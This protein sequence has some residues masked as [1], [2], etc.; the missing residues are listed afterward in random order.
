MRAPRDWGRPPVALIGAFPPPVGGQAIYNT[1]LVEELRARGIRVAEVDVASRSPGEGVPF[2]RWKLT[3]HLL[4]K[5]FSIYHLTASDSRMLG[6]E[7]IV[8]LA[9]IVRRTPFVYN[10]LA[11]RF[12]ARMAGYSWFHRALLCWS[13]RRASRILLSNQAMASE[14]QRLPVGATSRVEVVGCRLPLGIE[15]EEDHELL[16]FL[17]GG[18]PAIVAVGALRMVYGFDLLARA[19]TIL[20]ARGLRPHLLVIASGTAEPDAQL[21]LDGAVRESENGW[22]MVVRR[23]VDRACVLGAIRAATVLAR[24]TRADGDSLSIHEAQTLGVPVVASDAAPR[25]PGVVL[26]RSEDAASLAEAIVRACRIPRE[27][28]IE[29]ATLVE[30]V[31]ACYRS[32]CAG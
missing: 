2:T 20:T 23:D 31:V 12:A 27:P 7:L 4:M 13:L 14:L 26:H 10:I 21:A 22:P 24:P 15:P 3:W 11:G 32:V 28:R 19:C 8:A 5:R 16:E 1:R 29:D 9:S 18:G 25:P 6:F 17:K 30:S